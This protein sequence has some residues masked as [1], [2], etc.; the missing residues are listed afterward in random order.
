MRP[1]S[2]RREKQIKLK[3]IFK[4]VKFLISK[5]TQSM[6]HTYNEVKINIFKTK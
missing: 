6:L 5:T 1:W 4:A 3:K 2:L